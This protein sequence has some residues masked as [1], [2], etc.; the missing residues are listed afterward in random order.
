MSA[1]EMQTDRFDSCKDHIFSSALS[2]AAKHLKN[3]A[4]APVRLNR[5]PC[6]VRGQDHGDS[7]LAVQACHE[8][9]DGE[10]ADRIEADRRLVEEQDGRSV[11]EGRREVASHP[12]SEAELSN[13]N[14][15]QRLE[16]EPR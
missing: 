4:V 12:L 5:F 13:W 7:A 2:D 15:E 9:A 8:V 1:E 3:G 14:V 11:Q 10:L 6:V 16:I